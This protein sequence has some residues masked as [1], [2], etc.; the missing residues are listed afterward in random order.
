M[1]P[2]RATDFRTRHHGP[3]PLPRLPRA[4]HRPGCNHRAKLNADWLPDDAVLL[5][6]ERRMVCTEC[7]LIGADIRPDWSPHTGGPGIG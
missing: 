2:S 1:T 6:L 3:R 5:A 4:A 7:G